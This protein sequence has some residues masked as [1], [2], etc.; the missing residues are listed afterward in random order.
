MLAFLVVLV[1]GVVVGLARGGS[2]DNLRSARL[3]WMTLLFAA[4]ALQVGAQFVPRAASIAAFA[5]VLASYGAV[6]AWAAANRAASGILFIAIG[7]AMNFTVIAANGGMPISSDA[8]AD[9]GFI[10]P[11]AERLV[12]RGKHFIDH[13]DA[14]LAVLSDWIP[15]GG[16]P[17]AA[18]I[19]DLVL[20]AGLI[21]LLQD[22]VRGPRG[23]RTALDP[24]D[25]YAHLPPDHVNA[26]AGDATL[27]V[28]DLTDPS[29]QPRHDR[30]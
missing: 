5:M 25:E 3:R 29:E 9:A 1:L 8:A 13:G 18:S 6:F 2:L 19:G 27:R 7:A 24:R 16:H 20:W 28:I 11:R 30:T 22:L 4:A 17:S 26:A 23:R 15:L 10:G 21:L 12:L 14:R